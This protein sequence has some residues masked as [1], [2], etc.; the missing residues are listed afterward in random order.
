MMRSVLIG[1]ASATAL[2]TFALAG[3]PRASS[4]DER[5]HE[6]HADGA[7]G[8]S[9]FSRRPGFGRRERVRSRPRHGAGKVDPRR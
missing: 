8:A 3:Q 6:T 9:A 4:H 5:A 1:L 2:S 7:K